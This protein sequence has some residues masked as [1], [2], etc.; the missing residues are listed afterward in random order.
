MKYFKNVEIVIRESWIWKKAS[1]LGTLATGVWEVKG[2]A[3]QFSSL[4]QTYLTVCDPM[5]FSTPGFPDHHQ[6]LELTQTHVDR[7]NDAIQSFHPLSSPYPPVFDLSQ[8]QGL[9]Q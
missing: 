9:F 8:T 1:E 2:E 7:V 6:L 3:V 4:A 5:D